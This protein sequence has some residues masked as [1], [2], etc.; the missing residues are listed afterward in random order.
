MMDEPNN[1]KLLTIKEVQDRLRL[2]YNTIQK[3]IAQGLIPVVRIS[4]S[5]RLIREQDLEKFIKEHTG[6]YK[7]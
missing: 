4:R 3:Y 6:V 7:A 1:D 5:K 2:H